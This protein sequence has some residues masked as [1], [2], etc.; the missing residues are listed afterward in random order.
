MEQAAVTAAV[1]V[2]V[3]M[4][5]EMV[6]GRV[7]ELLAVVEKAVVVTVD[8]AVGRDWVDKLEAL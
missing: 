8:E 5:V 7:L 2:E 6:V 1:K 3:E 4:E